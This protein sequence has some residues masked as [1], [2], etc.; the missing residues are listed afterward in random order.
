MVFPLFHSNKPKISNVSCD[1]SFLQFYI[2]GRFKPISIYLIMLPSYCTMLIRCVSHCLEKARYFKNSFWESPNKVKIR[3]Y[4]STLI[5]K[6][7]ADLCSSDI[8]LM[9]AW[10]S[11]N[12]MSL[13]WPYRGMSLLVLKVCSYDA[14]HPGKCRTICLVFPPW[15][16]TCQTA[17]C[18]GFIS[19]LNAARTLAGRGSLACSGLSASLTAL[20]CPADNRKPCKSSEHSVWAPSPR[21]EELG[22]G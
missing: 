17:S 14:K 22:S 20:T 10:K 7:Y 13:H 15:S 3:T 21:R 19:P 12:Q 5:V 6:D 11:V 1:P 16:S 2:K 8:L 9:H 4:T 18:H